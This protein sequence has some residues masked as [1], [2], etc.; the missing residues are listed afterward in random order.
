MQPDTKTAALSGKV[1]IVTG[2]GRGIGRAIAQAY[3]DAGAAVV[4]AAR[5]AQEIDAV[6]QS[7]RM[8]GGN[9]LACEVDVTCDASVATLFE[10]AAARFGGIDIVVAN[11]GVAFPRSD[12][13]TCDPEHWKRTV[14]VNLFGA[15]HTARAAI[16]HLRRRGGGKIVMIGSGSRFRPHPG[17]SAYSTSKLALWMLTQTLAMELQQAN[18]SVNE[19]I[20]GPVRT[21]LTGFGETRF[22]PGEWVKEPTDVVPLALFLATQP[23]TGPTAQSFSLMRRAG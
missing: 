22:P 6:A 16:P 10:K 3:A 20:P 5:S 18:I 14:E 13:E 12:I 4:V 17:G 2:G 11:A 9:A 1:A 7:I 23:L 8:A 19:L 15:F 21:A